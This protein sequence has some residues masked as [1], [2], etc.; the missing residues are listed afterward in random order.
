VK[1]KQVGWGKEAVIGR[2]RCC[3]SDADDEDDDDGCGGTV[4]VGMITIR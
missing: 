3:C 2:C 1:S 4:K